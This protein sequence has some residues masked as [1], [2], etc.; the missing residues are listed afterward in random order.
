M[1]NFLTGPVYEHVN[2]ERMQ[3]EQECIPVGCVPPAHRL[4][5]PG[6]GGGGGGGRVDII[7]D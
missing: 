1:K 4:Y 2:S 7:I 5:L 6:P 3:K